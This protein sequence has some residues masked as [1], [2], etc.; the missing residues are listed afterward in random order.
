M[1]IERSS[2]I[3]NVKQTKCLNLVTFTFMLQSLI[4]QSNED[5]RKY[6]EKSICPG[7][8]CVSM[9]VIGPWWPSNRSLIPALLKF[10]NENYLL[11]F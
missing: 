9:L 2:I 1:T 7:T 8:L 3:C 11:K 4:V 10:Y 6:G 5:V